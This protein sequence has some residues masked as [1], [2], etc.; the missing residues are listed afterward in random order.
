MSS[1]FFVV[2]EKTETPREKPY[3]S[4]SR[5][6]D[7]A[8]DSDAYGGFTFCWNFVLEVADIRTN[9]HPK[10]SRCT[11]KTEPVFGCAEEFHRGRVT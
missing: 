5:C 3:P 7:E 9:L 6:G 8:V 2:V 10:K 4:R 1:R 11:R